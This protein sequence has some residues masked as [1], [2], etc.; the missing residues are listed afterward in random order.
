[1]I[2]PGGT[3]SQ[4]PA[5]VIPPP[6]P[7]QI[8]QAERARL[9]RAVAES[10]AYLD[11]VDAMFGR[12]TLIPTR[13]ADLM[14]AEIARLPS[15]VREAVGFMQRMGTRYHKGPTPVELMRH[16]VDRMG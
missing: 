5:G 13:A 15:A 3:A 10:K 6:S 4:G 16:I 14:K 12:H 9:A 2:A 11:R 1:M 8:A 7:Y